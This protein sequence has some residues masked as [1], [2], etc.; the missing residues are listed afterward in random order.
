MRSSAKEV[1]RESQDPLKEASR[2]YKMNA[3]LRHKNP[4]GLAKLSE[5]KQSS[6]FVYIGDGIS[7]D[8]V[9]MVLNQSDNTAFHMQVNDPTDA[10]P[11][12]RHDGG[13]NIL[14]I[15]GHVSTIRLKTTTRKIST[16]SITVK[17][18][19]SEFV[20]NGGTP[21]DLPNPAKTPEAQGLH[22]NPDMPLIWS[23]A[24]K[25]YF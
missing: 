1:A 9:G 5:V 22:R 11:A 7:Q 8:Q 17:T 21:S 23:D 4:V 20:N 2:T 14:F 24:P 16:P 6:N 19:E 25:L 3:L 18:W 13:A 15:D 10:S 12:L